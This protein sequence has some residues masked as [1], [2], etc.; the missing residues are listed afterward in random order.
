MAKVVI[1]GG[2]QGGTSILQAFMGLDNIQVAGMCDVDSQAQ[3]MIVARQHGVPA[4]T[5]LMAVLK[6][7]G[8]DVIIEATG[9]PKVRELILTNKTHGTSVVDAQAANIIMTMVES[10]EVM[11][12]QILAEAHNIA[13]IAALL[14]QTIHSVRISIDE[15]AGSAEMMASNGISLTASAD[16][17]YKHLSK[18]G[19]ILEF[20]KSIAQQ[21]KMLGLNAAIEAAR[22]GEHGRGFAVVA[23]EVRKLADN[24]SASVEQIAP[25]LTNIESSITTI[26]SGVKNSSEI[27]QKQA[28]VTQEVAASIQELENM[29][30]Q[31]AATA[32][33]LAS[34]MQ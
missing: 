16:D 2:G 20:I 3:G 9:S 30:A 5:D 15:V 24:S 17:A 26:G 4:L 10:R 23:E 12:Q 31:L 13:D 32:K 18:T 25:V 14:D 28:A 33:S 22:A 8:I 34:I 21:T 19:E 6:T 1:V 7:P 27:A 11:M 29:S